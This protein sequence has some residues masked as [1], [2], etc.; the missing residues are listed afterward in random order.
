[1]TLIATAA[2]DILGST[3]EFANYRGR[4]DDLTFFPRG[5][6]ATDDTILTCAVAEALLV[7]RRPDGSIN[8]R[9]FSAV[10]PDTL[11]RFA[12]RHPEG[13]YGGRFAEWIKTTGAPAYRSLGNGSALCTCYG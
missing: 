5:S 4:P 9:E 6:F 12:R 3:Y 2:G 10:L 13:D 11:R 1:M 7:A 8:E